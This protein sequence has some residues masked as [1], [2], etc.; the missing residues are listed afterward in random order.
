M[1]SS[2]VCERLDCP[3]PSFRDGNRM[4]AWSERVGDPNGVIPSSRHR[5]TNG[6]SVSIREELS[7][8]ERAFSSLF[9]WDCRWLKISSL[10]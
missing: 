6:C 9:M 8:K 1:N 2:A 4:S 10:L 7:R 3:G 5:L